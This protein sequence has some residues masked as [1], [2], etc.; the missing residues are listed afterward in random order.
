MAKTAVVAKSEVFTVVAM[1]IKIIVFTSMCN[2]SR[3]ALSTQ[4][5][6]NDTALQ[7]NVWSCFILKLT[8]VFKVM[9]SRKDFVSET[10]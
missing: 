2:V 9:C 7:I 1:K 6:R 10:P 3:N 8:S 4:N 5:T